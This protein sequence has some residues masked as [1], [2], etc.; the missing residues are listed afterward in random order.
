MLKK[1]KIQFNFITNYMIIF[2]LFL[3]T[4][5]CGFFYE[6]SSLAEIK[7]NVASWVYSIGCVFFALFHYSYILSSCFSFLL[8]LS[9]ISY[10][11]KKDT[12]INHKKI[13]TIDS[14][15]SLALLSCVTIYAMISLFIYYLI[16]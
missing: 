7:R 1:H 15:I 3:L 14:F 4:L 6:I 9:I 11:I 8:L 2:S 13:D 12:N 16:S 5:I 10:I